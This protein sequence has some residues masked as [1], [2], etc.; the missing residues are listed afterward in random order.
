[1]KTYKSLT[2]GLFFYNNNI[3]VCIRLVIFTKKNI[4][5]I[6]LQFFHEKIAIFLQKML[7]F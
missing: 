4:T 2:L 5:L 1:M 7:K 6:F 3:K